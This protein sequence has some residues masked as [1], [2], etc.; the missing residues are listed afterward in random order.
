MMGSMAALAIR[1]AR[2]DDCRALARL[3]HALWPDA[4]AEDHA[5]ELTSLL[6]GE[7]R[8]TLPS[9]ILVAENAAGRIVGFVEAGLRS[10]ADGC[11][12]TCPV[13]FIE[14]W[15]VAPDFRRMKI[16]ARLV[17]EA[18]AW[19]RA[20]GCR[21]MASDTWI[22]ALDSQRAHEALGYE[23]VDRCV[24]YRKIL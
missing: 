23:I 22:D 1:Q 5:R 11:D 2:L 15:Y 20:Q 12:P 19:A 6:A 10:H 21:E 3:R 13:G 14:G 24:N 8:S 16:G 4:S 18:E 7:I 9:V 17:A